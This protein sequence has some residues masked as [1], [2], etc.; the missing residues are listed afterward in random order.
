[1][2]VPVNNGRFT[3]LNDV[4]VSFINT[5]MICTINVKNV[6]DYKYC[7]ISMSNGVWVNLTMSSLDAI[8]DS[9]E[10]EKSA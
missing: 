2:L 1:M 10:K 5:D 3:G 6:G 4:E 8:L 7:E 9:V